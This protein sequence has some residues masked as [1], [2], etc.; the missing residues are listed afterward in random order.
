MGFGREAC[1]YLAG[2]KRSALQVLS[3]ETWRTERPFLELLKADPEVTE[4][5]GPAELTSL[6]DVQYYLK[7]ID[8]AFIRLGLLEPSAASA[9]PQG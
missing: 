8:D 3:M 2:R 5:I 9:R 1:V 6:F 4:H 7:H